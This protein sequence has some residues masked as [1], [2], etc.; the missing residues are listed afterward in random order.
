MILVCEIKCTTFPVEAPQ[1][2]NYYSYLDEIGSSQANRSARYVRNNL[3]LFLNKMGLS[4]LSSDSVKILPVVISNLPLATGLN[5][6]GVPVVDLRI[7][8]QFINS[9]KYTKFSY[10]MSED[11]C[12]GEEIKFYS[13]EDEAEDRIEEYLNNP[14]QV[15]V[16][17][18]YISWVNIPIE[19][20][21]ADCNR[22]YKA[23]V[24]VVRVHLNFVR[25]RLRSPH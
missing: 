24:K 3:L 13:S 12:P 9:G 6:N 2:Y 1:I 23:S 25:L 20:L 21:E 15:K 10:L 14:P 5:F 7:L 11:L 22:T 8:E 18:Q 19:Y 4:N 16:Y 17:E